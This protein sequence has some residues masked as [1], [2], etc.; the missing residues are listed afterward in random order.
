ML[1]GGREVCLHYATF[2]FH[3][4]NRVPSFF[5]YYLHYSVGDLMFKRNIIYD[6]EA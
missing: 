2:H 4:E 1:R 5:S 6:Q 3:R